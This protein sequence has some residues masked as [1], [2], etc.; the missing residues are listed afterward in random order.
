MM[1]GVNKRQ[2]K[3]PAGI[4]RTSSRTVTKM[5]IVSAA[6]FMIAGSRPNSAIT[7]R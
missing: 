2:L 1:K 6:G 5:F 7:A 3:W 4:S